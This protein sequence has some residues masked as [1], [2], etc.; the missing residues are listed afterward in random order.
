MQYPQ[1]ICT[2]GPSCKTIE[3]I[4][5]LNKAGADIFRVNMSH[6]DLNELEYFINIFKDCNI[7]LGIDTEGAQIRTKLI[8][9]NYLDLKPNDKFV[10]HKNSASLDRNSLTLYP[11]SV[12]D[13]LEIN[14]QLRIDF[15]GALIKIEKINDSYFD[16]ICL[17]GGVVANNKGVD[18]I[19]RIIELEDFT[20]KDIKA[21]EL[22]N[23]HGINNLFLSFCKSK[24]AIIKAR[25]IVPNSI[26][27]SKIESKLSINNLPEILE[28]SDNILIDRGDLS[29]EINI[30]D[31][32]FAQRAIIDFSKSMN[33]PCFIATNVLE[34]LINLSLPTR[35]ELN[36]IISNI[37][38]GASGIVLAAE[39]AIGLKPLLCVEIVKELI[40]RYTLHNKGLLF[41]D[42]DRQ[43]ITDQ[44]M[45]LWL[46]RSKTT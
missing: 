39:T 38:M 32:P 11:H 37:E 4:K 1:I 24:D 16:C 44:E 2:L 6:A 46:N 17:K 3:Q 33:K 30:M 13:L 27:T 20:E 40:H 42:I 25:K 7:Q 5:T 19:N 36:D 23:Q 12:N 43:E 9:S 14:M 35:A 34:S 22:A 45:R 28:Y 31:I 8:N 18:V 26:I 10:I 41:A 21:L 15:N 29:R